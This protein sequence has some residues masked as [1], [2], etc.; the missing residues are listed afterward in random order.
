[1]ATPL[2]QELLTFLTPIFVFIFVFVAM[3]A[4]LLKTEFF[5]KQ[6]GF[7]LT[8]AFAAAMLFFLVP[9]GRTVITTFT[10]WLLLFGFLVLAI[11]VIFMSLGVKSETLVGVAKETSFIFWILLIIV[12]LFFVAL[13]KAFGPFLMVNNT[14]GFWNSTKRAIFHPKTLGVLFLLLV[15]SFTVKYIGSNE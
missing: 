5:G 6:Q 9:E 7:N 13:T 15:A 2:N 4:L 1:M 11:F 3:Y 14:A 8:I 10:P 12:I